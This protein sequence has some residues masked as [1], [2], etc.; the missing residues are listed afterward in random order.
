MIFIYRVTDCGIHHVRASPS[1]LCRVFL[2]RTWGSSLYRIIELNRFIRQLIGV[3]RGGLNYLH[4]VT[5]NKNLSHRS[6]TRVFSFHLS[7]Q[8]HYKSEST[9]L[10]IPML[11]PTKSYLRKFYNPRMWIM[12][13]KFVLNVRVCFRG[14]WVFWELN[15][16]ENFRTLHLH[17]TS[18]VSKSIPGR[19]NA[20][21]NIELDERRIV[22]TRR[23]YIWGI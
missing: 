2:L 6:S 11:I 13:H 14:D 7:F 20:W 10:F 1:P 5:S 22:N 21:K 19:K 9:R 4:S 23:T 17:T 12:T 15:I 16:M 18:R 8:M 3:T